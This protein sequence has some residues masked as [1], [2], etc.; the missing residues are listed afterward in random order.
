MLYAEWWSFCSG[1]NSSK[2]INMYQYGTL[3][4]EMKMV[5]VIEMYAGEKEHT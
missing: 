3:F 4:L 5:H 1:L 2:K